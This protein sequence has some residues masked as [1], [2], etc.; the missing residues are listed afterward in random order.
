MCE[1]IG[2]IGHLAYGH[3]FCDGQTVKSRNLEMLL[4]QYGYTPSIKVDTYLLKENKLINPIKLLLDTMR[5]MLVCRHVFL[6]VSVKGMKF[7]LPFLF[8]LNKLFKRRIYHYIIGSELLEMVDK[9]PRL[10]V[11]LNALV[12][13]WFEFESGTA[14]LKSKGVRNVSTLANFKL[15]EPVERASEYTDM[16]YRFCT[17][18]RVMEEKG[19]SEAIQ[20]VREL[21]EMLE[22][23]S[24]SLDI[25]GPIDS[26]Y[27]KDFMQLLDENRHCVRY[28]GVAK[29]ECSVD[30]LKE[31][32]A[33]LFPTRWGGEGFP[34]TIIDAYA[35]A[36]PVIASDWNANAELIRHGKQGLIYPCSEMPSLR[37]AILWAVRNP[38]RMTEMRQNSRA[39]FSK[40]TPETIMREIFQKM[41]VRG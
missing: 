5:C 34:G 37:D 26:T 40:Y 41:Q 17:F 13:N 12:V 9:N 6:M 14:Y 8:Y 36:I 28:M 7:Y 38:E 16:Q 4:E 25:Y 11:Y 39:E 35:S 1:K 23:Q 30:V 20:A 24:I 10:V 29:S 27:E 19:I 22:S 3:E 31:Y 18:S 15:I 21:N 32:Y 33:L 2:I